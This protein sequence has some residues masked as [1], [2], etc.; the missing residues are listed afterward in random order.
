MRKIAFRSDICNAEDGSRKAG[1]GKVE[2]DDGSLCVQFSYLARVIV[3]QNCN[4]ST[5]KLASKKMGPDV[6]W[7]STVVRLE[8]T[9]HLQ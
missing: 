8:E 4:H 1:A 3:S 9:A 2:L 6:A 5:A 7:R